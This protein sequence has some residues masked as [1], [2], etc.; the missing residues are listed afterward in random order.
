MFGIHKSHNQCPIENSA[1]LLISSSLVPLSFRLFHPS[2]SPIALYIALSHS[3]IPL[4][5]F[6]LL[7]PFFFP[8]FLITPWFL[9]S[10]ITWKL[11]VKNQYISYLIYSYFSVNTVPLLSIDSQSVDC[12]LIF[13]VDNCFCFIS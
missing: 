10:S 3:S 13:F 6:A 11:F 4:P 1:E 12:K 5:Y 2:L 8:S 9:L 7:K